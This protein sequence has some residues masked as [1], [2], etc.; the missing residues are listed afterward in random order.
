MDAVFLSF[1]DF[2]GTFIM[3]LL[4]SVLIHAVAFTALEKFLP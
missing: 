4:A 1:T 2:S 3:L